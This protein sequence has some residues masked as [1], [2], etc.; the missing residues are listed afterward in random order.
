MDAPAG[1]QS[2]HPKQQNKMPKLN[3]RLLDQ[4]SRERQLANA[5]FERMDKFK[6]FAII[7]IVLGLIIVCCGFLFTGITSLMI[8]CILLIIS[9][10]V[11]KRG[12]EHW[13]R[14]HELVKQAREQQA[15]VTRDGI[16]AGENPAHRGQALVP[17]LNTNPGDTAG[18]SR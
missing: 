15:Q 5:Y 14:S 6:P 3:K 2:I 1:G 11:G 18:G 7:F 4:A 8:A 13:V 12:E 17:L 9:D 16:E 10:R